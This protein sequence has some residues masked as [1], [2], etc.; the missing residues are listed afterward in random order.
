MVVLPTAAQRW[1]VHHP[2]WPVLTLVAGDAVLD[3]VDDSV[4]SV[5]AGLLLILLA[6]WHIGTDWVAAKWHD[7]RSCGWCDEDVAARR[8]DVLRRYH[9]LTPG[10]LTVVAL[11]MLV[12]VVVTTTQGVMWWRLSGFVFPPLLWVWL[13]Y[14]VLRHVYSTHARLRLWC[15]WCHAPTRHARSHQSVT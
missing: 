8:T 14:G 13:T 1:I 11:V 7:A 15:P 4:A 6:G 3:A 2:V 12:L 5:A 10:V 9:R